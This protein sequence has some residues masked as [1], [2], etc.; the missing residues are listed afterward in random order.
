[1]NVL[2]IREFEDFSRMLIAGDATVINCPTIRTSQKEDVLD[3]EDKLKR[4]DSFDG[5]FLTSR[6]AAEIFRKKH[7]E[8]NL[9]FGGRVYVFGKRGFNVL[10]NEGFDL[11]G[12]AAAGTVQEMLDAI[13]PA[14]LANKRFLIICGENALPTV[15]DHLSPI[16]T[17][18]RTVVYRT[19]AMLVGPALREKVMALAK[20]GEI[21]LACFF[22]PSGA[23]SFLSQ[24]GAGFLCGTKVAVIGKTTA[25][26]FAR[27]NIRVDLISEKPDAADLANAV[28]KFQRYR[29]LT[30]AAH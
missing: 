28:L 24:F 22:S 29:S 9:R 4:L 25:E 18:E 14:E 20:R 5:I 19:E 3:L 15:V 7:R 30:A 16:A 1:M 6:K 17:V 10:K 2:V 13:A 26:Y 23:A 11:Y 21:A 12:D 8:Y 27:A